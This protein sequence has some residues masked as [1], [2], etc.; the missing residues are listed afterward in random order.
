MKRLPCIVRGA[1]DPMPAA[2]L[3][4]CELRLGHQPTAGTALGLLQNDSVAD[5]A[6]L[7]ARWS[8]A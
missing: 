7:A 8:P 3:S 4:G 5:V 2:E 6:A 1:F